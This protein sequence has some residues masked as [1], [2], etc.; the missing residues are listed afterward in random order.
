MTSDRSWTHRAAMAFYEW[1]V[2][3][4]ER[5][6]PQLHQICVM[7][8]EPIDPYRL[9]GAIK[10]LGKQEMIDVAR[11]TRRRARGHYVIRV[12]ST[13]RVYRTADCPL[14]LRERAMSE[15]V[16]GAA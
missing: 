5:E 2:V 6:L 16:A 11:G 7:L 3:R 13:G 14:D 10:W 9:A 12:R 1:L 15:P 4:E 8:P